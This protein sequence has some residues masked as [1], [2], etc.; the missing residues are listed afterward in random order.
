[1]SALKNGPQAAQVK[2]LRDRHWGTARHFVFHVLGAGAGNRPPPHECLS[3][4]W[5]CSG[6]RSCSTD[7]VWGRG[8][9]PHP[10][11]PK[12][13]LL[14]HMCRG[15]VCPW[16]PQRQVTLA[17]EPEERFLPLLQP[18]GDR[19]SKCWKVTLSRTFKVGDC[20][21]KHFKKNPFVISY[22]FQR[23]I[24]SSQVN[25]NQTL[26]PLKPRGCNSTLTD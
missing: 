6:H 1:M 18:F 7:C 19:V 16:E 20:S 5:V 24:P 2:I 21:K 14:G 22:F 10:F 8:Q 17:T 26:G 23:D 11:H 12:A 4:L 9:I 15:H 25:Q 13:L 3:I